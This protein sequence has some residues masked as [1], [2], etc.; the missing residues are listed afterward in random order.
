MYLNN[1]KHEVW[2]TVVIW[3][4][5]YKWRYRAGFLDS[6][7]VSGQSLFLIPFLCSLSYRLSVVVAFGWL[8]VYVII[9]FGKYDFTAVMS[10]LNLISVFLC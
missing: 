10:F 2:H 9:Y 6:V 7:W 5:H 4:V 1:Y 3:R 8:Y